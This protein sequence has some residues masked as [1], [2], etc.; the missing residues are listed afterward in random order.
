MNDDFAVP[1]VAHAVR[2]TAAQSQAA[3][4]RVEE[5]GAGFTYWAPNHDAPIYPSRREAEAASI[6]EWRD[7]L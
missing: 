4:D 3:R 7:N 5:R 2:L 6:Q 1:E